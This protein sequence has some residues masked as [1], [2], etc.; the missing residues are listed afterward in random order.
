MDVNLTETSRFQ[1]NSN[2][3][4]ARLTAQGKN[5]PSY[6]LNSGFR[7]ELFEG[8]LTITATVTDIFKTMKREFE[9][10]IPT[11]QQTSV[12][13]RDSRVMYVGLNYRF[14]SQKKK[15]KEDQIKYDDGL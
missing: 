1:L 3:N 15:A 2:Y 10:N 13:K 14:G 4:S 8:K 6:S 7:Q 12:N 5:K 9:L 11:L